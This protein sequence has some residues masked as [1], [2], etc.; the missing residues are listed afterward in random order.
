MIEAQ[1]AFTANSKSISVAQQNDQTVL[2]LI[3]GG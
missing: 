3:P 1:S 2:N